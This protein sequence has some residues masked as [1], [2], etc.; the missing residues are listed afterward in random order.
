MAIYK[1]NSLVNC[2]NMKQVG[3]NME[4]EFKN[5]FLENVHNNM[6]S[7]EFDS[8]ETILKIRPVL[9]ALR[10]KSIKHVERLLYVELCSLKRS[11]HIRRI[12]QRYRK[13]YW[14]EID[15]QLAEIIATIKCKQ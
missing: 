1:V 6:T 4:N 15:N 10:D 7:D 12:Y 8:I 9:D 5:T 13:L 11:D 14:F 2:E 3:K